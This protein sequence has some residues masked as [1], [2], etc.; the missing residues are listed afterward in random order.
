MVI[1]RDL[2]GEYEN[3]QDQRQ[4]QRQ[5]YHH[6]GRARDP[7]GGGWSGRVTT[8]CPIRSTQFID[9]TKRDSPIANESY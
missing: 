7:A 5:T 9:I 1:S 6:P 2:N 8:T 3:D 4:H